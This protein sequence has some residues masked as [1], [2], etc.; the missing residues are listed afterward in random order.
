MRAISGTYPWPEALIRT[1][2][3]TTWPRALPF[4]YTSGRH[5]QQGKKETRAR[6]RPSLHGGRREDCFSNMSRRVVYCRRNKIDRSAVIVGMHALDVIDQHDL[7]L[8][9][10]RVLRQGVTVEV[11]LSVDHVVVEPDS[12]YVVG[13]PT[14]ASLLM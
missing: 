3:F 5:G 12:D 7:A 8:D 10:I 11:D 9:V 13:L 2:S 6:R 4:N 14:Q 1:L